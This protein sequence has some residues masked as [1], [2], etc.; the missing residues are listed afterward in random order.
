M[1][2]QKEMH[3]SLWMRQGQNVMQQLLQLQLH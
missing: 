3:G 2:M 1:F